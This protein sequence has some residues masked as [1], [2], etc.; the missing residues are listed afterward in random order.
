MT[1]DWE[2]AV[3]RGSIDQLQRLLAT[4][5][6]INAR[7]GHNQTALMI[8]AG[9][10]DGHVVE[11]LIEHGAALDH[12]A[13]YGL[14]AL[15]LAVV[16]GHVDVVRKLTDAG[17][18]AGLCGTGA[19]G[20]AAKTALDLAIAQADPELV[21]I[22][23]SS[24]KPQTHMTNNP[25]F[26]TA[27]SWKAARTM[28]AFQPL[29]PGQTAGLRLQS[30][31]IHVRDHKARLLAVG[32]RTLEAHYGGF[33]LSQAR[34]GAEEAR[35]LALAVPYGLT[36]QDAQIAGRAARVYELGPEPPPDDIDGRPPAVVAWHDAELFCL[37]AS[38]TM[39]ADQLVGIALSLYGQRGK[40]QS[41]R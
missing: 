14:S 4:G 5:A 36:G 1:R 28:L 29:E 32:D 31:R 6:D 26:E 8:A 13:K 19:P 18:D 21:D 10:G 40:T 39:S 24:A 23:R 7:D 27:P 2:E 16:R 34:K 3:R 20:F 25:H 15:M 17:A 41:R 22:L 9:N 38:D 37:I 35:R 33:V 30:I 11:W 12:T